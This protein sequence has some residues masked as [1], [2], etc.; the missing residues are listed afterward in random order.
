MTRVEP[1][2]REDLSHLEPGLK[3]VEAAMGFVPT[4]MRT[5]AHVPGLTEAFGQLGRA[6][7]GN[8]L[9]EPELKAMISHVVSYAAGCRY[10]QAHTATT[11]T[12]QGSDR[13]KIAALWSFETDERFS[14]AERAALRLAF[15]AGHVPNAASEEDFAECRKYYSEEQIASIVSVIALFGYLNR[16]NDT[17]ATTLE[18]E[19]L[20]VATDVLADN[21]W[22]VDK[23]GAPG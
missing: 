5:M 17:M 19:P 6:V 1:I 10:C 23:H 21:G 7:L 4:S 9:L 18:E 15:H 2:A 8:P 14:D 11:A 16:W 20:A 3:L 12:H 13:E 22:V